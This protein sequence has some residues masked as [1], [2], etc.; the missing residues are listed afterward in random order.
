VTIFDSVMTSSTALSIKSA[1]FLAAGSLCCWAI[2]SS[3]IL[4][5]KM[6]AIGFATFLP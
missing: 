6:V 4:A 5:D 2:Q 1:A 3:I